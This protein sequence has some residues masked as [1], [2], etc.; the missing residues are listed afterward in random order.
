[1]L[2]RSFYTLLQ[3]NNQVSICQTYKA[4]KRLKIWFSRGADPATPFGVPCAFSVPDN[5][6]IAESKEKVWIGNGAL[7]TAWSR[8]A[9]SSAIPG[10]PDI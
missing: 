6:N 2:H 4:P 5:I 1:M 10:N 3:Q 8:L 7:L 9:P